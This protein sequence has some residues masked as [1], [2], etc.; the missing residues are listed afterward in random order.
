MYAL[1][2]KRAPAGRGGPGLRDEGSSGLYEHDEQDGVVTLGVPVD[3]DG[4][5]GAVGTGIDWRKD[6]TASRVGG[7]SVRPIITDLPATLSSHFSY[8]SFSLHTYACDSCGR[9]RRL[10]RQGRLWSA[11]IVTTPPQ[12]YKSLRSMRPRTRLDRCTYSH[13][14]EPAVWC[15][16]LAGPWSAIRAPAQQL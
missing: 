12:S 1:K 7:G 2:K 8:R 3:N 5:H 6:R 15:S 14:S 4:S 9:T 10:H 11:P 16:P 13:A